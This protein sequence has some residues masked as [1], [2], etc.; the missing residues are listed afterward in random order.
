MTWWMEGTTVKRQRKHKN[1][2]LQW[3]I[4]QIACECS[5]IDVPHVHEAFILIC[6]PKDNKTS[7]VGWW[8]A[9]TVWKKTYKCEEIREGIAYFEK[10]ERNR[11]FFSEELENHLM[12]NLL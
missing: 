9:D 11:K 4:T 10:L 2:K 8:D 7:W 12:E 3:H 6:T 5:R 1:Y